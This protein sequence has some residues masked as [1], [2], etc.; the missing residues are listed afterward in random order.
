MGSTIPTPSTPS[1]D[2]KTRAALL[3]TFTRDELWSLMS[4]VSDQLSTYKT[5]AVTDAES[6][7]GLLELVAAKRMLLEKLREA[8]NNGGHVGG[9]ES[10][11]K[12]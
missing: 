7:K 2:G 5:L 9:S 6:H 4:A 3:P 12:V 11:P 8:Y 1:F 10:V